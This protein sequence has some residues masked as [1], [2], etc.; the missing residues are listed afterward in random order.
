MFQSDALK[1]LA[2]KA[3]PDIIVTDVPYGNLVDWTRN[4]ENVINRLFG[5]APWNLP[6]RYS[7]RAL[8][9]QETES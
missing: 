8:Y 4:E 5:R 9:E 6:L 2:L 1:D 3:K 7:H